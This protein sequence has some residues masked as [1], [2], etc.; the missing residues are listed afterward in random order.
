MPAIEIDDYVLDTLMRDLTGH[1]RQ[2]SAFLVYL[3]LWRQARVLDGWTVQVSL[4]EL[5]DATGLSRRAV[6]N[7]IGRL[8]RRKLI[9]IQRASITAVPVYTVQR[10]WARRRSD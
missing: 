4:R 6:Q 9:G 10:P 1:D 5:A 2:P 8:H 7:A 3:S